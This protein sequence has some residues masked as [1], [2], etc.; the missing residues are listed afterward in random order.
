M[1]VKPLGT[2]LPH[3]ARRPGVTVDTVVL[4]ATAGDGLSGS[5]SWLR[6]I[7]LSYHYLVDRDGTIVKAVP[8]SFEA[9]H[10]GVSRGPQ[11]TGVNR[12]SVGIALANR[13]DGRDPY[14]LAQTKAVG[15]LVLALE[16][17]LPLKWL[18]THYW[19]SPGR[20]TD[21]IRYPIVPL[22]IETGL[23]VW[24]AGDGEFRPI[25]RQG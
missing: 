13:N 3:R 19:V 22:A 5:I 24:R 9:W 1:I 20:K 18:T 23:Q 17:D 2:W 15:E 25:G 7:G 8:Y 21:P 4:H 12:Y 10:V 11:G 6:T 16:G 14:T